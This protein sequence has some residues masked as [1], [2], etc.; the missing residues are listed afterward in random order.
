M[1]NQ[2]L[3]TLEFN[4][5]NYGNKNILF[6]GYFKLMLEQEF[7]VDENWFRSINDYLYNLSLEDTHFLSW[8]SRKLIY[9]QKDIYDVF[10]Y[11]EDDILFTKKNFD[12]W[13]K[14]KDICIKNNFNLGFI[15]Y[16]RNNDKIYSI[17]V[18]T[19]LNKY[20]IIDNNRFVVNDVNPYCA[21][22]IYDRQEL[23][24]FI[25]SNIWNFNWR[26]EFTYGV[27]EMSAVGWHGLKMTRYKDT[28]IPLV[29]NNKKK[30]IVNLHSLIHHLTNN[31]YFAH[32]LEGKNAVINNLV[33]EN[34]LKY[35][36]AYKNYYLFK[37]KFKNNYFIYLISNI[38][39]MI[40]TFFS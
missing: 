33:D 7:K 31:Y 20:L 1:K 32:K 22:W 29:K 18:T 21:F 34:Q 14:F 15:R 17:D 6:T 26:N 13:I 5:T 36:N 30:Y 25:K 11:S 27:R 23:S 38:F 12:Y 39:K 8:T 37:L 16:E 3:F 4:Q 40:K 2:E 9:E 28:L 10:I 35:N 19:K 24:K